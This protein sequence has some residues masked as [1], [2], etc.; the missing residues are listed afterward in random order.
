MEE[1]TTLNFTSSGNGYQLWNLRVREDRA[2]SL[3]F[4]LTDALM[5]WDNFTNIRMNDNMDNI[6][7]IFGD[8]CSAWVN[9]IDGNGTFKPIYRSFT[10]RTSAMTLILSGMSTRYRLSVVIGSSQKEG[11]KGFKSYN[12]S[13]PRDFEAQTYYRAYT[14]STH[15]M[16]QICIHF[17]LN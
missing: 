3:G 9:L 10:S 11:I 7:D 13:L 6:S 14:Q 15:R 8:T 4:H 17:P 5:P 1:S 12:G 16:T 2:M